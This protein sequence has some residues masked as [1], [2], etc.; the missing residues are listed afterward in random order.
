[1]NTL[2][3]SLLFFFALLHSAHAIIDIYVTNIAEFVSDGYDFFTDYDMTTELNFYEG[4]DTLDVS[5]TYR[6]TRLP[7]GT[8]HPFA[9]SD[10]GTG[11]PTSDIS[12]GAT[13]SYVN[14][15]QGGTGSSFTLSFNSGFDISSD[16]LTYYC[17]AHPSSMN[18]NFTVVPEPETYAIL[19]GLLACGA[20]LY[21]R[22][23]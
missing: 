18:A 5:K 21:R 11:A 7:T 16:T 14:D 8:G 13:T 23:K 19:A 15:D 9:I 1:M 4:T 17:S 20:V 12:I 6:F 2:R 3:F 22:R 10:N